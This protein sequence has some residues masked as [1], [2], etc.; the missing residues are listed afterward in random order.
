MSTTKRTFHKGKMNLD[1][2]ERF[3][4][5][6]EYGEALNISVSNSEGSDVGAIEK[7]LSN[8][9]LT[10]LSLGENVY[11]LGSLRDE[12]E[13]KIYW[14]VLS[15]NGCYVVEYEVATEITTFVLQDTRSGSLN[16]LGFVPD[17]LVQ[18]ALIVD[19]DNNNRI[20]I[21]S[22]FNTQPK[23]IN[24]E[25]AKTYGENGFNEEA[26]LLIKK[27]PIYAPTISL[28]STGSDENNIK[29]IFPRFGCRYKY[30]DGEYSAISPWSDVAFKPKLFSYDYS[31][32]TNESMVNTHNSVDISF[33]TG[34][35]LVTDIEVVYKESGSN[36]IYLI[37]TLN[38]EKK[39]WADNSTQTFNFT[40]SKIYRALPEKELWRLYDNVPLLAK[41]LAV[42]NNRIIF[43]NYVENF[44]LIDSNEEKIIIDLSVEKTSTAI[45]SGTATNSIKSNRD[46]EVCI[47][48]LDEFGRGLLPLSSE[49][50]SIHIPISDSINQ[51][52]IVVTVKHNPPA[53]AKYYRFF[54][55]LNKDDYDS[56][57]PIIFYQDGAFRWIKLENSDKDKIKEGDFLVVKSDSSQIL[58]TL[59][60]VKV[61]E[62]STK[63]KNFLQPD[64]VDDVISE[65][66]GLYFKIKPENFRLNTDDFENYEM[67]T[68]H[69]ARR[70]YHNPLKNMVPEI[71]PAVFYGDTLDD[72]TS[73]GDYNE[74]DFTLEDVD[75]RYHIQIDSL[76]T[77]SVGSVTL[78]GG[79]SGSVDGITVNGV[80]IMSVPVAFN[81]DLNTTAIAVAA[82]ITSNTSSPNYTAVAVGSTINITAVYGGSASNGHVVASTTTTITTTTVNMSGGL[83][84]TFKWSEDN[85]TTYTGTGVAITPGVAQNLSY[86][87]QVTFGANT[88]HSL[89]DEWNIYAC[90]QIANR[91]T[92]A[93]G[94]FRIN[95][96]KNETL[97]SSDLTLEDEVIENGAVIDM[98]YDEWNRGDVY[99][100]INTVSSN[101][102]TNIIEW[103]YKEDIGGKITTESPDFDL[104]QI[105]FV[106]GVIGSNG[107]SSTLS[108]NTDGF[109][110]MVV[111]SQKTQS[112]TKWVYLRAQTSLF[113]SNGE[114]RLL[115]ETDPK[116]LNQDIYYEVGQTY[117]ITDGFHIGN[118]G[119]DVNQT[120]LFDAKIKL[121]FYNCYSWGNAFE[122]YKI[123][124]EFNEKS[125]KIDTR[126][127]T[128]IENYR[129]NNRISSYTW[130]NV[131]EQSANYNAINE[132]NLGLV[133]Y[134][135]LDDSSGGIKA[136]VSWENDLD[137]FQEDKVVKVLYDGAMLYNKDGSSNLSKTDD[138]LINVVPYSGEFGISDN[139]ES[140]SIYG[141][142]IYWA[143]QKRGVF[144]RKGQSGIEIISNFG[145]KDWTRDNMIS[146]STFIIGGYDPY[147]G[148]FIM[149]LNGK[150]L[151]FSENVKGWTSFHSWIPDSMVRINNRFFTIK[152]GQLYLHND[153]DNS[154]LNTFYGVKYKS[155]V[156]TI[157]NEAPSEDKVL[158]NIILESTRP[159]KTTIETNLANGTIE[160]SEFN[161]RESKWFAH[162]RKNEN[163]ADLTD[164]AQGIGNIFLVSGSDITFESLPTLISIGETLKQSNGSVEEEIGTITDI[165][166]ETNIIT[167]ST[168]VTV[169][170]QGYF[171][172][173]VK[174]ARVQGSELRGY[175]AK[176]TLENDDDGNV[177]LFA[178][179]SNII[180]SFV[181]TEYK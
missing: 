98:I 157:L 7:C 60:K 19:S 170:V 33:D 28:S 146:L 97:T 112:S 51:N 17:K 117:Q 142:Y 30:L 61:L 9:K 14:A 92:H 91:D 149:S 89:L 111:V 86:G 147:F 24:I 153:G 47:A 124:D 131:Y 72:M 99:W 175:Y 71:Q 100:S 169:P 36:T 69:N 132:F 44:N 84:N 144:L 126:Q 173:S 110:T 150:T 76:Q 74:G 136:M 16:V 113:Q 56:L 80:A 67:S 148:L 94:F 107:N 123:R 62:I 77:Q 166:R 104:G 156:V 2:D 48:Y 88:G 82:N 164:R 101:R 1:I 3:I 78:T 139:P 118:G 122:S 66:A 4:E 6:G 176:L 145:I 43:G 134:R 53:F 32:G 25:R 135:D 29:E 167:V 108:Y 35:E 13:E 70:S 155:E 8:K 95:G 79:A 5:N 59:V 22:D 179:N 130:S 42:L 21:L 105:F 121:P 15:D 50:N 125:M 162:T 103:F 180:Q 11:T 163:S 161:K 45:V 49:N 41:A 127:S 26:I 109:M 52:E 159:W 68:Y 158:K 38:K 119:T 65:K 54:V 172:Y 143:D 106:R 39:L 128:T 75:R 171:A 81:T 90:G 63:E 12:F 55:K 20:L 181:P 40:N 23:C 58:Q 37:E 114:N 102:Y 116:L 27:P 138:T 168:I 141:N 115:F 96:E 57:S 160:A 133:N 34:S 151:T 93:Y 73:G 165:N 18:M 31:V 87:I 140:I 174:N 83:E 64:D 137:I 129:Q 152:D 10:N 154:V 46:I 120:A 178:V 177:E 85:G